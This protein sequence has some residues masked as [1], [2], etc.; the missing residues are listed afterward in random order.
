MYSVVSDRILPTFRA[1]ARYWVILDKFIHLFDKLL[2]SYLDGL[3]PSGVGT[4]RAA[5]LEATV[6]HSYPVG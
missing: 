2:E 1:T 5:F 3:V 4:S 6:N